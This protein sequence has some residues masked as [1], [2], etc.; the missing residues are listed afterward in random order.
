MDKTLAVLLSGMPVYA[1][2][3]IATVVG[4]FALWLYSRKVDVDAITSIGKVQSSQIADLQALI[5]TLTE[6]LREA[7]AEIAEISAQNQE[8]RKHVM[9]LEHLLLAHNITP[10]NPDLTD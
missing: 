1:T 5:K 10:P 3:T 4:V 8:L 7:R 9:K 6:E 2:M